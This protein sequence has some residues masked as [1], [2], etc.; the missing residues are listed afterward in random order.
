MPNRLRSDGDG[1]VAEEAGTGAGEGA[2]AG[3]GAAAGGRCEPSERGIHWGI[4]SGPSGEDDPPGAHE[5]A[6]GSG[7]SGAGGGPEV[8]GPRAGVM[9]GPAEGKQGDGG[10]GTVTGLEKSSKNAKA[11]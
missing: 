9:G 8:E 7:G 6:R 10:K 5:A 2:V 11:S 1:A 4:G 3:K